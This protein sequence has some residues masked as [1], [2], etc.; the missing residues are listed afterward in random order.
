MGLFLEKKDTDKLPDAPDQII[1]DEAFLRTPSVPTDLKHI[2]EI[3]LVERI[4]RSLGIAWT[5]GFGLAA[6]QIGIPIQAAWY[7]MKRDNVT[8]T[9][10]IWNPKIIEL[11]FVIPSG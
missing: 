10:L 2:E 6:V 7:A 11:K 4:K 8:H 3:N 1:T 9:R 5:G